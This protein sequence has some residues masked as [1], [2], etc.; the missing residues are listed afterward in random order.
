[1]LFGILFV[2]TQSTIFIILNLKIEDTKEFNVCNTMRVGQPNSSVG[3]KIFVQPA[4]PLVFQE[5]LQNI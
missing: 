2:Q 5:H 3:L 1:M 4:A